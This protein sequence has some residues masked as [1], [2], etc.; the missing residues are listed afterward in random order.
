MHVLDLLPR[1][2]G[3]FQVLCLGAHPD[4]IEIGCGGLVLSLLALGRKVEISWVVFSAT[5]AREREARRSAARFLRRA[6]HQRVR[7]EQFRDGY[8]PFAGEQLKDSFER[9]AAEWPSPDLILTHYRH[10]R[11][12][13][14]RMVSDLT[15]N[16]YR[17]HLVLEYEIPKYDGDL[18]NPNCLFPVS[19]GTALRKVGYL[20]SMFASQRAKH[21]FDR[22]TV[23]GLMR[24]RGME[25]RAP[26]GYAEGFH[27]R[28]LTIG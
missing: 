27:A 23:L 12:Q 8:F 5:T 7:V 16:T 10:D 26:E 22:E 20:E 13:D 18:G 4:D 9:A 19:R 2:R 25:C 21:W 28:K 1:K 17:D 14:H 11:H 6:T 24:L 15:W 3:P